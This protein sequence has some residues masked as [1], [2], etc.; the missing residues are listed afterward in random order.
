MLEA[1]RLAIPTLCLGIDVTWWGG[2]TRYRVSQR[3]TIVHTIFQNGL[4]SDLQFST[5]DLSRA[6]NPRSDQPT[7][8]N[9]D[10][11]AR[12]L[13]GEVSRILND[14]RER[15]VRCIVALDAPLEAMVRPDQPPRVKAVRKGQTTG[16]KRRQCECAIQAHQSNANIGHQRVWNADLRIQS[17]SPVPSRIT[18]LLRELAKEN[19]LVLWGRDRRLHNRNI[20]EIFPSEAIWSLGLLGAYPSI[21][22]QDVRAYKSKKPHS[23]AIRLAEEQALRPLSGFVRLLERGAVGTLPI[24]HW[25]EQIAAH[26]R[27]VAL[28]RQGDAVTKGKGFD[29]PIE[30]G[31]AFLTG[32]AFAL[33]RFHAWGDGSD[34]T[35]VGPGT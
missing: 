20:I 3:D 1:V 12:L 26:A 34:G 31:I 7:E 21:T 24:Q 29:D 19:G 10:A 4:K 13:A 22:S 33:G 30:S 18:N 9:F 27:G 8:A 14:N 15:F 17:G 28:H 5:V 11:D 23:L 32:V 2:S 16:A 25:I 35:I 6:P